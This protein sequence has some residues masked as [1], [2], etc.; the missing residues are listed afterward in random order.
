MRLAPMV[1]ASASKKNRQGNSGIAVSQEAAAGTISSNAC[2]PE[3]PPFDGPDFA[4]TCG[5][6]VAQ[7]GRV[8]QRDIQGFA[9][10]SQG[11][12]YVNIQSL[13]TSQVWQCSTNPY[14]TV[15]VSETAYR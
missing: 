11:A 6:M 10:T 12:G 1:T 7:S 14:G 13:H 2:S 9:I 8:D 4:S 5:Q 3:P 15:I